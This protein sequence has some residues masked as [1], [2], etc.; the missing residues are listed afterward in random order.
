MLTKSAGCQSLEKAC[1]PRIQVRLT[2]EAKIAS[3]FFLI[4]AIF[5][6]VGVVS[7]LRRA[8]ARLN[9][10]QPLRAQ[11]DEAH[12]PSFPRD[13]RL[14][15]RENF[16]FRKMRAHSDLRGL[17][18]TRLHGRGRRRFA[19]ERN[20]LGAAQRTADAKNCP[21]PHRSGQFFCASSPR[22]G[23]AAPR[24]A[25]SNGLSAASS[26]RRIS[27]LR[28]GAS[29]LRAR[30]RPPLFP[31]SSFR[32]AAS[33]R[34]KGFPPRDHSATAPGSSR[35]RSGSQSSTSLMCWSQY[36]HSC[37]PGHSWYSMPSA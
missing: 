2:L 21:D 14:A 8:F 22:T 15:C 16:S 13:L 12:T 7:A 10:A 5:A 3:D 19:D 30:R 29:A 23:Q 32:E 31:R 26:A 36:L 6:V 18:S 9:A 11:R 17:R 33:R 1:K 4:S 35:L 27:R 20:A 24:T 25:Q 37:E 28:R 34:A